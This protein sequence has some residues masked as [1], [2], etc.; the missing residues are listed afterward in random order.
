MENPTESNKISSET[1]GSK[2]NSSGSEAVRQ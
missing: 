2:G 1:R